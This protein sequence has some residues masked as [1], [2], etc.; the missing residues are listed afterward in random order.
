MRKS[1]IAFALLSLLV[2]PLW[3]QHPEKQQLQHLYSRGMRC[4]LNDDYEQLDAYIRQYTD[5]YERCGHALGDSADVFEAYLNAMQG[6]YCYG[7]A[8]NS[9]NALAATLAEDYYTRSLEV[10]LRRN[11]MDNVATLHEELAQLYYKCKKY[12]MAKQHLNA[13]YA[14]YDDRYNGFGIKDEAPRYYR[15]MSQLAMCNA[16]IGLFGLATEQ[17]NTAVNDFFCMEKNAAY[18][19][20]LRKQGKILMLRADGL[21]STNYRSAVECYKKYVDSRCAEIGRELDNL[22]GSTRDQHWL[23]I[24]QFLYDCYRLGNHAPEMLYDLALFSKDF[25]IRRDA[26]RTTW[27]QVQKHI[28]NQE[29]AI[30]FVQYFGKDDEKRMGCLVLG[31]EGKPSFIDLFSVDSLLHSHLDGSYYTVGNA[32]MTADPRIKD[33]LYTDNKLP[34]VIWSPRLL[35]AIGSSQKVFFAPDGLLHQ[36][37]IEYIIPDTTKICYRLS[38]TRNLI[39][40]GQKPTKLERMLIC[41]GIDFESSYKPSHRHNDSIAYQTIAPLADKICY[42]IGTLYEA[43]SI[44]AIRN[45]SKD[46]LLTGEDATDENFLNLLANGYDAVHIS[47]HGFYFDGI[48]DVSNDIKE[49]QDDESMSRSGLALAGCVN[50]LSD[51][52][53]DKDLYDGV[54]SAKEISRQDLTGVDLIVLSA[55]QTA[56]GRMTDDGIYGMQRGLKLAGAKGMILTLWIVD[57]DATYELMHYFYQELQKQEKPDVRQAFHNAR[58]HLMSIVHENFEYDSATLTFKNKQ[59]FYKMPQYSCPFILIDIL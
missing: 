19:E 50:T 9:D 34:E 49:L 39:Q 12:E 18:Y 25:L 17:I 55:C 3:A 51:K 44:H 37:A 42:L 1:S 26:T 7:S 29:C 14:Y 2:L 21:G 24:H 54:L 46:T 30:E 5:V 45:N 32:I 15:A 4:Y 10:F 53:F 48:I 47:T 22:S 28:E 35:E 36:L 52:S 33:I 31:H 58:K 13:V 6:A 27:K 59:Y 57:D 23:A 56:Q 8:D 38:S 20:A 16:R 11:S 40:R 43:E 41:G